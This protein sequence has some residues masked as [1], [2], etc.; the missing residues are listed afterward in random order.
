MLVRVL[1]VFKE[2]VV[3]SDV[4]AAAFHSAVSQR[5]GCQCALTAC[6]GRCLGGDGTL[7]DLLELLNDSSQPRK[8][9]VS[10]TCKLRDTRLLLSQ[11]C[12]MK[13]KF[14]GLHWHRINH[15]KT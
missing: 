3:A 12:V 2:E 1:G 8:A 10:A 9:E 7:K 11:L 5:P 4:E 15:E 14:I 13:E 6:R